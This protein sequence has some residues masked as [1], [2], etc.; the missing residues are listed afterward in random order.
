MKAWTIEPEREDQE[1]V[2]G[3]LVRFTRRG[4]DAE[5]FHEGQWHVLWRNR[6]S[7]GG[8][9]K[10]WWRRQQSIKRAVANLVAGKVLGTCPSCGL[11]T[12]GVDPRI[13]GARGCRT[14]RAWQTECSEVGTAT[15][16]ER[17]TKR[18]SEPRRTKR[19]TTGSEPHV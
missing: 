18:R 7:A 17:S 10:A 5:A 3:T 13:I 12:E 2:D 15:T 6:R 4:R 19:S 14:C 1:F 16:V 11:I 9:A 8:G